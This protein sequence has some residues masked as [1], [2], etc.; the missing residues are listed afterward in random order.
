MAEFITDSVELIQR[1]LFDGRK[2]DELLVLKELIQ[3]ADDAAA[4]TLEVGICPGLPGAVHPLL[5]EQGLFVVNDGEF[6]ENHARAIRSLGGSSKVEEASAIGKFGIGLKSVFYLGEVFFYLCRSA[7]DDGGETLPLAQVLNPWNN[8]QDVENPR[9]EWDSFLPADRRLMREFLERQGVLDGFVIWVPLRTKAAVSFEGDE[10]SVYQAYPGD[11]DLADRLFTP[12][13]YR[14]VARMLP[15]MRHLSLIRFLVAEER[16]ELDA[17]GSVRSVYPDLVGERRFQGQVRGINAPG[18]RFQAAEHLLANPR[19]DRLRSS[20]HW[21]RRRVAGRNKQVDDKTR[22]HTA[23]VLQQQPKAGRNATLEIQWAAF[24]PL[25]EVEPVPLDGDVDYHLTLHGCF[26]ISSDRRDVLSWKDAPRGEAENSGQLQQQW[27]AELARQGALPLLLPTLAEFV[28]PLSEEKIRHLSRGIRKSRLFSDASLRPFLCQRGNWVYTVEQGWR[29]VSPT[30]RLLPYPKCSG[31]PGLPGWAALNRQVTVIE[32]DAP[33]LTAGDYDRW[34]NDELRLLFSD[35]QLG[36][37]E[38]DELKHVKLVLDTA[39]S[40]ENWAARRQILTGILGLE[41]SRLNQSKEAIAALVEHVPV[42]RRFTLPKGL[43]R[44]TRERLALL[45]TDLLML[46]GELEV[47]GQAQ[48]GARDAVAVLETLVGQKGVTPSITAVLRNTAHEDRSAVRNLAASLGIVEVRELNSKDTAFITPREAFVRINSRSLFRDTDTTRNWARTLEEVFADTSI[49][50]TDGSLIEALNGQ[51]ASFDVAALQHLLAGGAAMRSTEGRKKLLQRLIDEKLLESHPGL[52]R[53]VLHGQ[54]DRFGDTSTLLVI[55]G[56][57]PLLERLAREFL[58][59]KKEGWKVVPLELSRGLNPDQMAFLDVN[60][61]DRDEVAKLADEGDV[62]EVPA[63]LFSADERL[64]LVKDLPPKLARKLPF[65]ATEQGEFTSLSSATMLPGNTSL[66]E[67]L[68]SGVTFLK[69]DER[70]QQ[71]WR[72]LGVR[73]LDRAEAIRRVL[74]SAEPAGHTLWLLD[75]L[76]LLKDDEWHGLAEKVSSTPWIRV[77][78]THVRPDEIIFLPELGNTKTVRRI[79][80]PDDSGYWAAEELPE[81][82]TSHAAFQ[83]LVELE[84][85]LTG[86]KSVAALTEVMVQDAN[87]RYALGDVELTFEKW[88]PLFGNFRDD[89]LPG[90]EVVAGLREVHPE[91]AQIAFDALQEQLPA[92]GLVPLLNHLAQQAIPQSTEKETY[93]DLHLYYLGRLAES[94]LWEQARER[95]KLR[96]VRGQWRD[97]AEMCVGAEG[98]AERDVLHSSHQKVLGELI[99]PE[100]LPD[101]YV[102]LT[103]SGGAPTVSQ[104]T[105]RLE[106]Y[107]AA[108]ESLVPGELIGALCSVL[109]GDPEVEQFARMQLGSRELDV[110]RGIV[111][112]DTGGLPPG[113]KSFDDWIGQ[114]RVTVQITDDD[115]IWV[116]SLCDLPIQVGRDTSNPQVLVGRPE[117]GRFNGEFYV[118]PLK[119]NTFDLTSFSRQQL[120]DALLKATRAVLSGMYLIKKDHLEELWKELSASDQ[121]DLLYT[122]DIIVQDS[123]SYIK[124]QLSLPGDHPLND[125]FRRW[126]SARQKEAEERYNSMVKARGVAGRE[127]ESLRQELRAAFEQENPDILERLLEAVRIRVR[128]A[129]YE[130]SSIPFELLQ[131]ADDALAELQVMRP[132]Q[133]LHDIFVVNEQPGRLTFMHWGRAINQ[134]AAPGFDGEKQGFKGDLRKMLMLSAS[135]KG[136]SDMEVTGKFGMGFKTVYL[137]ADEPQVISGRLAF[138]VLGG[139]YPKQLSAEAAAGIRNDLERYGDRH[140]GTAVTLSVQQGD[141]REGLRDFR[142]WLAVLLVFTRQVKRVM[143]VSGEG[144]RQLSWTEM[145]L[146]GNWFIG[147]IHPR[148]DLLERGLVCRLKDGDILLPLGSHGVEALPDDVPTLWVTAPTRSFAHAGIAVNADF[149]LDIGRSEVASRSS[150]NGE[151]IDLLGRQ[152]GEALLALHDRSRNWPEFHRELAIAQGTG[153]EQ[154]W[155]GFWELLTVHA[156]TP[157]QSVAGHFVHRLLWGHPDAG[158]Y[159]LAR[160]RT[161]VPTGLSGDHDILTSLTAV[162]HQVSGALVRDSTFVFFRDSATLSLQHPPGTL[163]HEEIAASLSALTEGQIDL[164]SLRLIDVMRSEFGPQPEIDPQRAASLAREYTQDF[165]NSLG[166]EQLEV[167]QYLST[168]R[169][170]AATGPYIPAPHLVIAAQAVSQDERQRAAF[171]PRDRLLDPEYPEDALGFITLCRRQLSADGRALAQWARDATE[172]AS[173]QAALLYLIRGELGVSLA[174]AL[175]EDPGWLG[176]LLTHPAFLA[177]T[178][179]DRSIL[180]GRLDRA[181]RFYQD[182][183]ATQSGSAEPE[184]IRIEDP[185]GYLHDLYDR[186]MAGEGREWQDYEEETYPAYM[187]SGTTLLPLDDDRRRWMTLFLMGSYQTLGRVTTGHTRNFLELAQRRGWIDTFSA[188]KFQPESWF[189]IFEDFLDGPDDQQ[190]YHWF[191]RILAT[192][193]LSVHLDE[194]IQIFRNLGKLKDATNLSAI[195]NLGS[196]LYTGTGL[197]AP[198]LHRP[199]GIGGHFVLRELLRTGTVHAPHLHRDAYVPSAAVRRHFI[200]LGCPLEANGWSQGDS[201]VIYRFLLQHLG[202]KKATFNGAFDLPFRQEIMEYDPS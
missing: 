120:T 159:A 67:V 94:G 148:D 14:D 181:E 172:P 82:V 128:T 88:W 39:Q 116:M 63:S 10:L 166:D 25:G 110:I 154:F 113:I 117:P 92:E 100:F 175:K 70:W 31:T 180:A 86:E 2:T 129:Q 196:S 26:F 152:F 150:S 79:L 36:R 56:R 164:P 85:T 202:E 132:S 135:D 9:P 191:S 187:R 12:R 83:R 105:K 87:G 186:W 38:A 5:R 106:E 16:V 57:Q 20:P 194:Y 4:T 145:P 197:D 60:L 47:E 192:Y 168:F 62:S 53:A 107:F 184:P 23:L 1:I 200:A 161:V 169:F 18:A 115:R 64:Q 103:G 35:V 139:V 104:A 96:N 43:A 185:H 17:T 28:A 136:A 68:L 121:F 84:L 15:L 50:F 78:E 22:P 177:M 123:I 201:N 42:H 178:M 65:H 131:N 142:A 158:T 29:L 97:A 153:P 147:G 122:Q 51:I 173:Q 163:L 69:G 80:E 156:P 74:D 114:T 189:Q 137:L 170:Q 157:T 24:L 130:V 3:N 52:I 90:F 11:E 58:N 151:L 75:Q 95:L 140:K 109:G 188:E 124:H 112:E 134:F 91:W 55:D 30:T 162:T 54:P 8:G 73:R 48:F 102:L 99:T 146:V 59:L 141:T 41:A 93:L 165:L 179:N 144:V 13:V 19:I 21:P 40:A 198:N 101:N 111:Q 160:Q 127:I 199:L 44:Q 66:P 98:V 27:N 71:V 138:K 46:P 81:F 176:G 7:D 32:E 190:Y 182:Q 155:H 37:M 193:Q 119:L 6:K 77:G 118:T 125:L 61:V 108:W 126:E 33:H 149:S 133:P 76:S 195:L 34:T 72:E 171:A 143:D 183:P 45:E 89:L 167:Q 174:E 49:S